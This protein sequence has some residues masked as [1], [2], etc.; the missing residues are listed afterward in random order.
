MEPTGGPTPVPI[1]LY[2]P[3]PGGAQVP[4]FGGTDYSLFQPTSSPGPTT[5]AP[6]TLEPSL[7]PGVVAKET[8][9]TYYCGE[10][11]K[12]MYEALPYVT[13]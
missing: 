8:L 13:I 3:G 11:L 7:P 9:A 2:V 12:R 4:V 5:S 10:S 6:P 1:V